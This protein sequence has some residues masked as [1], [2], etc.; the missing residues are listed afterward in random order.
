MLIGSCA[1]LAPDW[2]LTQQL[3]G[4]WIA[5]YPGASDVTFQDG[6][7]GYANQDPNDAFTWSVSGEILTIDY[8]GLFDY[9]V[10]LDGDNL[11]LTDPTD[12]T[13]YNDWVRQ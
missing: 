7:F 5:Q 6:G 2:W 12:P 13:D 1:L 10:D 9:Y 4:T 8:S 11:R 3:I